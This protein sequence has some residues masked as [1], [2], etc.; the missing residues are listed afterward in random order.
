MNYR[1]LGKSDTTVSELS[2][3]GWLTPG[4]LKSIYTLFSPK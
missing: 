2:L 1:S 4:G 3:G